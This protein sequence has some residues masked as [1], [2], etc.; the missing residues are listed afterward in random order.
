VS[1]EGVFVETEAPTPTVPEPTAR[2][3]AKR[4]PALSL[5][6]LVRLTLSIPGHPTPL[7]VA[8]VVVHTLHRRNRHGAG[9]K[10]YALGRDAQ[11]I[12]DRFI[13]RLRDEMPPMTGRAVA[14][15][16]GE[17]FEPK[18]Y[19]SAHQVACLRIYVRSVAELYALAE[20]GIDTMFVLSDE[21]VRVGDEL[22]LQLVHPDSE[23]IFELSAF[24]TRAVDDGGVRGLEVEFLDLD[25]ERKARLREFI[26]DG[27]EA[28]FDEESFL[29]DAAAARQPGTPE[30]T[31]PNV[32]VAERESGEFPSSD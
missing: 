16:R 11:T 2:H 25:A 22:G 7:E 4:P 26:D 20:A 3:R 1:F 31:V 29:D 14:L 13:T 9:L 18:L 32:G 24:V 27:L 8:A 19:R 5:G 15:P 17:H 28:L 12:W 6:A 23:D 10:F 21:P 30:V